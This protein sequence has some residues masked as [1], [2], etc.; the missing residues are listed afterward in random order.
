MENITE[1]NSITY[2]EA[3]IFINRNKNEMPFGLLI[4]YF[5]NNKLCSSEERWFFSMSETKKFINQ[6]NNL[7]FYQ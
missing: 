4:Q 2:N 1:L 5:N 7:Y 6:N 3:S